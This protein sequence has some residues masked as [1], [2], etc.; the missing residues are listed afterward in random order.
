MELKKDLK[1]AWYV[2]KKSKKYVIY[3]RENSN[4]H[5]CHNRFITKKLSEAKY[6]IIP[7]KNKK[8]L[9]QKLLITN[10]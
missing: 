1:I 2:Y 7:K 8:K 6:I 5:Y 10:Y 3:V 4:C 9:C